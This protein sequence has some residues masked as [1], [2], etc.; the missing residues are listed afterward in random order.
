MSESHSGVRNIRGEE[1]GEEERKDERR[2]KEVETHTHAR[3]EER[4]E[5][6]EEHMY[7]GSKM[8]RR[9][10]HTHTEAG[11]RGLGR[12]AHTRCAERLLHEP[13]AA[14]G[15][16]TQQGENHDSSLRAQHDEATGDCAR[17]AN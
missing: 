6:A 12:L 1:K 9:P 2:E 13:D 10:K 17:E 16:R 5:E 15:S 7:G 11:R 4:R 3:V 8:T 14:A